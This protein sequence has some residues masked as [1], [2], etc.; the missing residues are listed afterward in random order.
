MP[1]AACCLRV[2][3]H[4]P[5][6]RL[7]TPCK[8]T[9]CPCHSLSQLLWPLQRFKD[10]R[11]QHLLHRE[12]LNYGLDLEPQHFE[13]DEP[14]QRLMTKELHTEAGPVLAETQ[15]VTET[16]E[17][18]RSAEE[19]VPP[20]MPHARWE[21]ATAMAIASSS[22]STS[23]NDENSSSTAGYSYTWQLGEWSKCSQECGAAGSG[24]Q[25]SSKRRKHGK[26]R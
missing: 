3:Q 14:A 6:F 17:L 10:S 1:H 12:A 21:T 25:V 9:S 7:T 11:G 16:D 19:D 23:R 13:Q 26:L 5:I 8:P 20:H 4:F 2:P 22:S 24:L 18:E 15:I